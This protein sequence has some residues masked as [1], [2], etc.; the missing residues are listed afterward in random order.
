MGRGQRSALSRRI[1][2]IIFAVTLVVI[3]LAVGLGVGIARKQHDSTPTSTATPTNPSPSATNTPS[4]LWQPHGEVTW[5][6]QLKDAISASPSTKYDVWGIDLVDNSQDTIASVQAQGS[7]VICYFSA[8]SYESWRPDAKDFDQADLG[9][10]LKGWQGEKWVNTNS[11]SVRNVMLKR[12]D[13]AV[14]KKCNGVDPDNMDGYNNDNGFGLTQADAIDYMRFLAREAQNR[15]LSIGLKN[16]LEII[17]S[18]VD[19]MQWAVNEQCVEYKECSTLSPFVQQNKPVLH[20]EYPKGNTNNFVS[21]S[22]DAKTTACGAAGQPGFSTIIK[23][24]NLDDWI[25]TCT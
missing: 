9:K 12:L 16:A 13:L 14:Q 20:V 17:P 18:V 21:V 1:Y 3:A 4:S 5:N 23:N 11:N 2:I 8:G 24:I 19:I 7:K 6:Y 25:E 15:N 22:P 10:D